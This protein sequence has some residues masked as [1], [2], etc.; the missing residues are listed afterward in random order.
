MYIS[1]DFFIIIS[2]TNEHA[3]PPILITVNRQR[4]SVVKGGKFEIFLSF[5]FRCRKN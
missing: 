2:N 3:E 5:M 1:T 4:V